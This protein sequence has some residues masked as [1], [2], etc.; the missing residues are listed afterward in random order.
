M[1]RFL[2]ILLLAAVPAGLSAQAGADSSAQADNL[3]HLVRARW[4]E[5]IVTQLQLS[6]DQAGKL[7]TTEDKY[8]AMRQPIQQRQVAIAEELNRQLQPGV[9]ANNDVVN[10]LM[11][12][13]QDNR[14]RLQDIDRQQDQEMA[15]Y[16]T[17]VQRVRY[18]RQRELFIRRVQQFREGRQARPQR[19]RRFR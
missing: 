13:R 18:Q 15:G 12:E 11:T 17:P 10:K 4:H 1:R 3:R 7:Q 6:P 19:P 8:D 5:H 2:R 14:G 9:G 16:L